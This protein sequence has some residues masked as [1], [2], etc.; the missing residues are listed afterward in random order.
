[1]YKR[2]WFAA[3]F[4]LLAGCTLGPDYR[5]PEI[6]A[7]EQ[8]E[9]RVAEGASIAN[10]PWWELFRDEQ[11]QRLIGIAI[12]E[13]KDLAIATARVE[14]TRAR[15][16]FVRADQ[17]P[18]LDGQAGAA[19]GNTAEQLIPDAGVQNSYILSAQLTFEI[20]LFGKLRRQTESARQQLL[21]SEEARRTVLTSLIADVASTYFLLR[22][23]DQRRDI[24]ARTLETR[25]GST[26]IIRERFSK[27][28]IPKIDVNQAEIQEAEAAADLAWA[29]P[30]K[31]RARP[32]AGKPDHSSG[33]AG[34]SALGAA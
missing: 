8:F 7:P 9:Q 6:E 11:L 21:A 2:A 24:A 17:Y 33:R 26:R 32:E 14:E 34:W 19:R 1:M 18:R 5:R 25:R 27:G 20:D 31:N 29:Q 16:G 30:G 12:A 10:L 13:N 22:D 4:L 28:I 3:A 15:L 23:L